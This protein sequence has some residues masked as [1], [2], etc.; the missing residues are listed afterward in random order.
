MKHDSNDDEAISLAELS[1]GREDNDDIEYQL[2]SLLDVPLVGGSDRAFLLG[3]LVDFDA[4]AK[5]FAKHHAGVNLKDRAGLRRLTPLLADIADQLDKN[6][7]GKLDADELAGLQ[8]MPPHLKL[9]CELNEGKDPAIAIDKTGMVEAKAAG[10]THAVDVHGTRLHINPART[11]SAFSFSLADNANF[12]ALDADG[13]GTVEGDEI[14]KTKD[15]RARITAWDLD[16]D[17]KITRQEHDE[18]QERR[19]QAGKGRVHLGCGTTG[20]RLFDALDANGDGQLGLR[21]VRDAAKNLRRLDRDNDGSVAQLELPPATIEVDLGLEAGNSFDSNVLLSGPLGGRAAQPLPAQGPLWF[22][23]MD[24]NGD[25]DVSRR[26]F[27]GAPADFARLDQNKDDFIDR[28][29]A[30]AAAKERK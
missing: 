6:K 8:T 28:A 24:H 2:F 22:R 29:E 19:R 11:G 21:E 12:K 20:Q 5:A 16:D 1:N 30:E 17:G 4:L 13:N 15:L 27:V 7:D 3:P 10:R 26:E 9:H 25:G 23:K 18:Y 14:S